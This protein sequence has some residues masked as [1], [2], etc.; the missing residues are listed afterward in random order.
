MPEVVAELLAR[1]LEA[2]GGVPMAGLM[3]TIALGYSLGRLS[4]RQVSLGPAGA[5]LLTAL[6]LGHLGLGQGGEGGEGFGATGFGLGALGFA[7]FI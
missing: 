4:V 7:L 1:A 6:A 2:L 5:T 3:F